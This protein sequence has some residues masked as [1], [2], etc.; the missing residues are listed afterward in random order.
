MRAVNKRTQS[1]FAVDEKGVV[2]EKCAS[3]YKRVQ[4]C[5]VKCAITK[6]FFKM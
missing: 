1:V 4:L 2:S 3:D 6:Q 5:N